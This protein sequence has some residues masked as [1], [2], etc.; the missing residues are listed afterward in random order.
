MR[1]PAT[2]ATSLLLAIC[3]AAPAVA[4]SELVAIKPAH[5]R[6][7]IDSVADSASAAA[8]APRPA[9][10]SCWRARPSPPCTAFFLTEMGIEA[11]S[12]STQVVDRSATGDAARGP[13]SDIGERLVWTFGFLGTTGRNSH[14]G[15]LSFAME[16]HEST[17]VP[18]AL[19]YRY[20]RWLRGSSALDAAFGYR[21]MPVW[22]DGMGFRGGRGVTAM[23]GYTFSS[24]V[25]I[26][27]RA[28]LIRAAGR[29]RRAL[30]VGIRST[31]LSEAVL[32]LTAVAAAR[33]A[34]AAIGMEL[35]EDDDE[36]G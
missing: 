10:P 19:E 13:R 15:A 9:K 25:A 22:K 31:R 14:G 1:G 6:P 23:A 30:H 7:A 26:S 2:C 28:D 5:V 17:R 4:Q 18:F 11:P 16:A 29:P 35:D 8:A 34:L 3:G 32:K 36:E 20:R 21:E 12:R 27:L 24:Y 33:A